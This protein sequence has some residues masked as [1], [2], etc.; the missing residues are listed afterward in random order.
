MLADAAAEAV[1]MIAG[2]GAH[3]APAGVVDARSVLKPKTRANIRARVMPRPLRQPS[4]EAS[5]APAARGRR[6]TTTSVEARSTSETIGERVRRS[7][8]LHRLRMRLC[9]FDRHRAPLRS[10]R[11]AGAPELM[12]RDASERR[13]ANDVDRLWF[14]ARAAV[15]RHCCATAKLYRAENNVANSRFRL[16]M[17]PTAPR[18]RSTCWND[19]GEG[20]AQ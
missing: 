7:R 18:V 5:A 9:Y 10:P 20:D 2:S 17:K 13:C 15:G 8:R 11:E 16:S 1:G 6:R 14:V 4:G 19:R 12:L 3:A